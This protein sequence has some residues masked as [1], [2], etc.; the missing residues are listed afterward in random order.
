[1]RTEDIAIIEQALKDWNDEKI[2]PIP[3]GSDKL[4]LGPLRQRPLVAVRVL[5]EENYQIALRALE[6]LERLKTPSVDEPEIQKLRSQL[7]QQRWIPVSERLPVKEGEDTGDD[8]LLLSKWGHITVGRK[9]WRQGWTPDC[10]QLQ[11]GGYTSIDDFT[12]WMPL[13]PPLNK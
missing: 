2:P 9:E 10:W 11:D 5:S 8:V 6:A 4:L 1:M 7:A 13:P 12:H 3:A